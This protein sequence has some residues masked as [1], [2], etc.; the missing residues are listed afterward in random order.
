MMPL[1]T[2]KEDA[3]EDCESS[4][5][6]DYPSDNRADMGGVLVPVPVALVVA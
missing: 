1:P 4:D 5:A 6:A 2:K 3:D